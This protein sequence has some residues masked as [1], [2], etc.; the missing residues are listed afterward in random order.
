M[1]TQIDAKPNSAYVNDQLALKA[2]I[3]YV[4][5]VDTN[6][7]TQL[8]TKASIT[9]TNTQLAGKADITYVDSADA[10]LQ[11]QI[12]TKAS[13]TYVD[14]ELASKASTSYVD[15]AT[16]SLQTQITTL[17]SSKATTSYVDTS[18]IAN[19]VNTAPAKLNTLNELALAL[20][21]DA[22][23][24]TTVTKELATKGRSIYYIDSADANLQSQINILNNT[25]ATIECKDLCQSH[26]HV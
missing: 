25:K 2:N 18:I 12:D 14:T 15:S 13:T 9:Y 20:G 5:S 6:L 16:S 26:D 21:S 4:D 3:T 11:S 17:D 10:N 24:S 23:F 8:D 1:Q 19:L 22:N 7:Q